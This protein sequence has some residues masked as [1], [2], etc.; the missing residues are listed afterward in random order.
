MKESRAGAKKAALATL[1]VMLT[2]SLIVSTACSIAGWIYT[3]NA[4]ALVIYVFLGVIGGMLS[5]RPD[6]AVSKAVISIGTTIMEVMCFLT[7]KMSHPALAMAW[8]ASSVIM[9]A[10]M[11]IAIAV[12]RE[13]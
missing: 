2:A 8:L 12:T 6:A 10:A 5:R 11:L 7:V 4:V 9:W 1:F 13:N 3:S